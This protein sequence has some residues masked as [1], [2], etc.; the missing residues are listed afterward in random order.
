M[1]GA[2]SFPFTAVAQTTPTRPAAVADAVEIGPTAQFLMRNGTI[3]LRQ[4]NKNQPLTKN[5]R[6][7]NGTKINYKSGIVELMQGKMTTLHEGDYVTP[8]GEIVFATPASAAAARGDHSVASTKQFEPYV[9]VGTTSADVQNKR[10]ELMAKKIDLL[11]QKV[12]L[13]SGTGPKPDTR[14]LDQQLQALDHQ[15]QQLK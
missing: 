14:Q 2:V 5:I 6:L 13:L 4:D 7:A 10:I 3:V 15:L 12:N 8:K 1:S 9:Q 11:N